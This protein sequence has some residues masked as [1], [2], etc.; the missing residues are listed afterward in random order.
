KKELFSDAI[1]SGN[2]DILKALINS[3][4]I[5]KADDMNDAYNATIKNKNVDMIEFLFKEKKWYP[6]V[7]ACFY[8]QEMYDQ[9]GHDTVMFI[10]QNLVTIDH[11]SSN[12]KIS[13]DYDVD[14]ISF[15]IEFGFRSYGNVEKLRLELEDINR[16]PND[17]KYTAKRKLIREDLKRRGVVFVK[18]TD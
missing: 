9:F 8:S 4:G 2:V 5:P 16:Y 17:E 14:L 13:L 3:Y 7:N 10:I 18:N 12:F 11:I 15:L 1:K 6:S